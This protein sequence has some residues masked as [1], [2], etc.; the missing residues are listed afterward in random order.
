VDEV[1][2]NEAAYRAALIE[3]LDDLANMQGYLSGPN[4]SPVAMRDMVDAAIINIS[5]VVLP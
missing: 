3:A 2:A 5:E 4:T 1:S